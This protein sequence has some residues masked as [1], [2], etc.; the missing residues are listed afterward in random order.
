MAREENTRRGGSADIAV[1]FDE[2]E[3]YVDT[4]QGSTFLSYRITAVATGDYNLK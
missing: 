2:E 4:T 3:N 1:T